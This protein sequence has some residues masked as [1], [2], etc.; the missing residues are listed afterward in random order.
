MKKANNKLRNKLR[1]RAVNIQWH[2]RALKR[3]KSPILDIEQLA[4]F[5]DLN[6]VTVRRALLK[7][8]NVKIPIPHWQV[9]WHRQYFFDREAIFKWIKLL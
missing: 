2:Y 3:L 4:A 7:K 1:R 9:P 5:L 8:S 6:P